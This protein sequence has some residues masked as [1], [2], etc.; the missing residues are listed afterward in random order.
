MRIILYAYPLILLEQ[1]E[2]T[3]IRVHDT[4][5]ALAQKKYEFAVIEI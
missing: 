5:M 1:G 3:V 4:I 2:L